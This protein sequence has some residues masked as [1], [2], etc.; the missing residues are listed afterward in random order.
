MNAFD[1]K[2][3]EEEKQVVE[4]SLEGIAVKVKNDGRNM[5]EDEQS[6]F[7]KLFERR[8][9]LETAINTADRV[10]KVDSFLNSKPIKHEDRVNKF[11]YTNTGLTLRDAD[12]A[13]K[14]FI[15]AD[16]KGLSAQCREAAQRANLYGNRLYL[17]AQERNDYHER[18]QLTTTANKGGYSVNAAVVTG[19]ENALL[20]YGGLAQA[21]TIIRTA[22]GAPYSW[23]TLD[24][25]S[26]KAA[27]KTQ[28]VTHTNIDLT[29]GQVSFDA[30]TLE[31]GV[32][33]VSREL[34]ADAAVNIIQ[35]AT[36]ALGTRY[37]RKRNEY[38]T[39]GT[40]S[41]QPNG[42]VTAAADSGVT[43]AVSALT[44]D[45]LIDLIYSVDDEYSR[46][47]KCG[48]MMKRATIAY[49]RKLEDD[50]GVK[51][52]EPSNQ[53]G[54][55]DKL[56]GFPVWYNQDMAAI[57]A[58]AKSCLFGDFSK[59]HIREVGD[60]EIQVLNERYAELYAVGLMAH[61]RMDSDLVAANAIK[62]LDHAAS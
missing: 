62:F 32:F 48:F 16:T 61:G 33:P 21:C 37:A 18:A 19:F 34:I 7:D 55:P 49:I 10:S 5:S 27:L 59:F 54:Q 2:R 23:L 39:T 9:E 43:A 14:G 13:F 1:L 53:L 44:L 15:G 25:T 47:P 30:Y 24:D 56:L 12:N 60:V 6:E 38:A 35:I 3:L 50:T 17:T 8:S 46:G 4:R 42:V 40:G 31:S 52:W 57:G 51:L 26:N 29:F 36:E 45:N 22:N 58:S 28:N 41:S 20:A 11:A